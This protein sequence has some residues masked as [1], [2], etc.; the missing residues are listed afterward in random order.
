M[1]SVFGIFAVMSFSVFAVSEGAVSREKE[2]FGDVSEGRSS[3]SSIKYLKENGIVEGYDDNTFRPGK[4]INRAEFM[5]IVIGS[6]NDSPEGADCFKDVKKE[7]Y[8]P[9][10]CEGKAKGIV[11]GYQDGYFR[12][13]RDISFS[14]ASKIIVNTLGVQKGDSDPNIWYKIFVIGLEKQNAIPVSIS[15]FDQKI[16][17]EEMAE[18]VYRIKAKVSNKLSTSFSELKGEDVL[19]V[20]SCEELQERFM[21]FSNLNDGIRYKDMDIMLMPFPAQEESSKASV[22]DSAVSADY[23]TTNIQVEG[24]DEADIVKN[25][26]KYIYMI[27]G[28]TVRIVRAYPADSMKEIVK[29]KLQTDS[30]NGFYP[31]EMYVDGDT[32]VIIGSTSGVYSSM[33]ESM[34]YYPSYGRTKIFVMDIKDRA[35]PSVKR[36]IE[37]DGDYNASRKIGDT[38][39]LVLNRYVGRIY[40]LYDDFKKDYV[41]PNIEDLMPKMMDSLDGKEKSIGKCSDVIILPKP[42]SLN[43][44]ITVAVPLKDHKKSVSEEIIVGNSDNVYASQ[45]NLYIADTDWRYG[46]TESSQNTAIYK[47][48][49]GN[50]DI[51]YQSRGSIPGTLLN[52]FSM[53]EYNGYF[54]VASTVGD[55]WGSVKSDNVIY[56]LN[57]DMNV[58]G[59]VDNIAKGESIYSVRFMGKKAYVVTF[60]Y[61]DP[62]FV[63]DLSN[64]NSPKVL[65]E[66]KIPGYSNYLHPYDENHLIGFGK[67][68]DE[69]IDAD[70]VHSP[71]AVYY[72][73]VQGMKIGMFDVTDMK[74]PKEMF[75]E[76]IGDRGTYSELLDNHKALL[77]DKNKNLLAFPVT[78]KEYEEDDCSKHTYSTCPSQCQKI[79]V[80]SNCKLDNGVQICTTDCDGVN[81]CS[82]NYYREAK[83][84]FEGAYVYNV[85]LKTGFV[86]KGKIT[87]STMGDALARKISY[88]GEYENMIQRIIYIGEN[89]YTISLSKIKASLMSDLSLKGFVDIGD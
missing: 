89:L 23:S 53:D 29:I 12:P 66:L 84:V 10:I 14:E 5:K 48:K 13:E 68:V 83:T 77:F 9:Y 37:F 24:V 49:L 62:L 43:Y 19:K 16:T 1:L 58:V 3:Y 88:Y 59:L 61:V 21:S 70:K 55:S 40:P 6:V 11:S 54:R 80:P 39:Y 38:A 4:T 26:G 73:A 42:K 57:S 69:T 74:N 75:K 47:F 34:Y 22:N 46:Y 25:D 8:A 72:T 87:H 81:S 36:S 2:F 67:E 18:M 63:I 17:R 52:Q 27:K 44:I 20:S 65:G 79:C 41:L 28:E 78:V 33:K 30:S 85:D 15:D 76:V 82:L 31:S 86:L 7:W 56:V 51:K 32:L 35:N 45:N 71:D 50:G 64:P 60:K